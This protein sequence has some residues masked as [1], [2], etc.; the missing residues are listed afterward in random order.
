MISKFHYNTGILN[1]LPARETLRIK[2]QELKNILLDYLID[3]HF[4]EA[5]NICVEF[6]N[7][8]IRALNIPKDANSLFELSEYM[9][10][11]AKELVTDLER[12]VIRSIQQL[13]S[14][15]EITLLT[16]HHIN[17]NKQ[18][19]NW[20]E[21]IKPI[22]IQSNTLSE[23]MKSESED[24]LQQ[25]ITILNT[26]ID[27]LIPDF[28]ILDDMDD[29]MGVQNYRQYLKSLLAKMHQIE[30]KISRINF[31]ERLFKFPE[32]MFPKDS[33]LREIIEPFSTLVDLICEWQRDHDVWLKGPFEYLNAE[34]IEKRTQFY[35]EKIVESNK[36]F[37]SK[38]KMDVT[39]NKAF[40]FSGIVDDPDPMQQPAPLKLCWQILKTIENFLNFV[41]LAICFCNSALRK[42][43]WNEMSSVSGVN[44]LPN[45]GT[46][47]EKFIQLDL[48]KHIEIF[49]VTFKL[50]C[51]LINI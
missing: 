24:E 19:I 43:H 13:S 37:K 39:A 30:M 9:T 47:L 11:G 25:Q 33:E 3:F 16:D 49:Q 46:T 29:A 4:Q 27:I 6:E 32:T 10:H 44:L 15:L 17:L 45:A 1:Q 21:A 12:R 14:L 8:K 23:A 26:E 40:K 50:F 42:R 28:V 36:M 34:V 20:L 51:L 48:M 41:P 5:E 22:F 35:H 38:I 2:T 7:L 31:E 18:N